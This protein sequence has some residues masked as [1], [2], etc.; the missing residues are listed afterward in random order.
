MNDPLAA[1][2]HRP[3]RGRAV[4]FFFFT[5]LLAVFVA[6]WMLF[7]NRGTLAVE[8]AFPLEVSAGKQEKICLSQPCIFKLAPN[9]Y[10]VTIKK[11]EYFDD[12]QQVK[13]RRFE[14]TKITANFV[15]IPVI[16]EAD[17]QAVPLKKTDED[18]PQQLKKMAPSRAYGTV[19]FLEAGENGHILKTWD[20]ES[21][22]GVPVVSFER[23]F[24][25]F[26]LAGSPSAARALITDTEEDGTVHYLVD[27][28]KKSRQRLALSRNISAAKWAG[29]LM[30][31]EEKLENGEHRFFAMNSETLVKIPLP[32]E[33]FENIIEARP[34]VLAF[35]SRKKM[36]TDGG[37]FGQTISEA[38][39]IAKEETAAALSKTTKP[40][41]LFLTEFDTVKSSYKSLVSHEFQENERPAQ[42]TVDN[43]AKRFYF[44][45]NNRVMEVVLEK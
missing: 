29:A 32:S 23:P 2:I 18:F 20:A 25:N 34:G 1:Q 38:V 45:K 39:E 19:I 5:L 12:V 6:A 37:I 15:Y 43:V 41:T 11:P 35:F 4:A 30:I 44:T 13:I 17:E 8:G 42:L 31:F 24:K 14:E 22:K 36:D 7:I 16:R 3:T 40:M 26:R 9:T 28:E 27:L 33:D 21:K 10:A